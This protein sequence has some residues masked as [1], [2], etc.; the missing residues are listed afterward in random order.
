AAAGVPDDAVQVDPA[1]ARGLDYYTGTVFE[2]TY[3]PDPTI[4]S[5]CSGGRYDDLTLV[6]STESAPGVGGS[7]GIDRL[8]AAMGDRMPGGGRPAPL[9]VVSHL[10]DGQLRAAVGVAAAL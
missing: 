2:T 10:G 8:L 5:V 7:I 3:L 4:G 1:I 9:V 6:Y